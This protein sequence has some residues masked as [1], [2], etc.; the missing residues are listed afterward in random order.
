[1]TG[2]GVRW[3][4]TVLILLAVIMAGAVTLWARYPRHHT[5][6]ISLPPRPEMQGEIYIGGAVH[7]PGLYP[8][9]AGDTVTSLV[10]AAGG[11]A[12]AA[13]PVTL[14]LYVAGNDEPETQKIDLNRAEAWLLQA[15]PDIGE[16]KAMAIIEYRERNGGFRH[17]SEL[18]N[19]P[20]IGTGTY[21]DIKHLVT[22]AD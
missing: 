18:T 9:R 1:M 3:K 5:V 15:L 22:V 10:R 13:V 6:E 7:N 20:G 19:V 2:P 14:A 12:A 11:T 8:F 16:A 4:I 17:V 21:E